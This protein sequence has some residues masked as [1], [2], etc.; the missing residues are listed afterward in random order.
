M[1]TLLR[2]SQLSRRH[3]ALGAEFEQMGHTLLVNNYGSSVEAS[4]AKVLGLVDLST[5][6]RT[7]FKGAG[8]TTWVATQ[9]AE[10]PHQPNIALLQEDHSLV[11]KLSHQELLILSDIDALSTQIARLDSMAV[12]KQT[13]ALP[14]ADSH[15]WLAVIGNQAAEMFSK[16]CGVDLRA[17]KFANNAVTQTSVAKVSAIIIRHDL[18]KTNCLYVLTDVSAAEFLWDCLLDA[19]LEYE[20]VPVGVAS[21]RALAAEV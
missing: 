3:I 4:K 16:V 8:A 21:M 13:Y 18:G 5:L 20:G 19:M 1:A 7:G 12:G 10:L 17:H 6:P 15:C 11:V 2:R 14:R 9:G